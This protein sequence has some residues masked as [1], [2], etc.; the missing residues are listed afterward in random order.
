MSAAGAIF[1][2]L[3]TAVPITVGAT[4]RLHERWRSRWRLRDHAE[5]D[6]RA[7]DGDLVHVT[8]IVRRLEETLV[9]PLSGRPCVAY[10]SRV[11]TSAPGTGATA[12][13]VSTAGS[14]GETTQLRPFVLDLGTAGTVVVDGDH[15]LFGLPPLKL[16]P[17][18]PDREASF[19]ARHALGKG[20]ANFSEVALQIGAQVTVGGTLMLVPREVPPTGELGF[21]DP[22]PPARE[23]IGSRDR[24][25]VIIARG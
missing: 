3:A 20:R 19:L 21:R 17:R 5:L 12:P 25:L 22:I 24:P 23:I 18:Q 8:G 11:S 6:D 16:V 2:I 4:R 15:A 14:R 7:R 10:R 1:A 9:A 13:N